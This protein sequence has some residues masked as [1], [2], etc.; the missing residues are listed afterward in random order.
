MLHGT[1]SYIGL[2]AFTL[3]AP[4]ERHKQ[5]TGLRLGW[6][7]RLLLCAMAG[8]YIFETVLHPALLTNRATGR[9]RMPF[10]S[11]LLYSVVCAIIL[12]VLWVRIGTGD[13]WIVCACGQ[14]SEVGFG[15]W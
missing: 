7:G 4:K 5:Q 12:V 10:L 6:A 1:G 8:V 3:A 2:H 14:M 13:A 9:L 11:L 15:A